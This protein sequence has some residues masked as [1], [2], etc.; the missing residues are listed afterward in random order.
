MFGE[1]FRRSMD[2]SRKHLNTQLQQLLWCFWS[3][4]LCCI[5]PSLT[6]SVSEQSGRWRRGVTS[7][8]PSDSIG[9]INPVLF[10]LSFAL[11]TVFTCPRDAAAAVSLGIHLLIIV[12]I[13]HLLHKLSVNGENA[14]HISPGPKHIPPFVSLYFQTPDL[15]RRLLFDSRRSVIDAHPI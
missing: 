6:F 2:D 14:H 15:L 8:P 5:P 3:V 4:F 11:P 9:S 10:S 7:L 12:V 13:Y 1:L